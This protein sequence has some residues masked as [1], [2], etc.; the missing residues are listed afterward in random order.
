MT[1]VSR[2]GSIVDDALSIMSVSISHKLILHIDDHESANK[3]HP[4][5]VRKA[6]HKL[7][8]SGICVQIYDV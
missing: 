2:I 3:T 1:S 4:P 7:R 5:V 6:S 8:I